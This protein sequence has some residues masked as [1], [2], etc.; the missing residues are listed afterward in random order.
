VPWNAYLCRVQ[1]VSFEKLGIAFETGAKSGSS[2]R[3]IQRF[4]AEYLPD[5]DLI[6]R[7]IFKILPHNPPCRPAMDRTNWKFGETNIN[8]LTLA[9][10]YDGVAF[11]IL[12]MILMC[13]NFCHVLDSRI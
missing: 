6:E 9:I 12:I 7:L 13:L 8:V 2:L 11:P 5:T 1:T 4:M 3:R 10:V